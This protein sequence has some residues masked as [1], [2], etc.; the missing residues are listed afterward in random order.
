MTNKTAASLRINSTLL[1]IRWL[2]TRTTTE[3]SFLSRNCALFDILFPLNFLTICHSF[4]I[5]MIVINCIIYNTEIISVVW[6]F[7][8]FLRLQNINNLI[9]RFKYSIVFYWLI[10]P[11]IAIDP[12]FCFET[13]E[14]TYYLLVAAASFFCGRP[15]CFVLP[16]SWSRFSGDQG[17]ASDFR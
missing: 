8:D 10:S 17:A 9:T 7:N 6:T 13:T 1:L 4:H 12:L 3:P 15:G 11:C 5:L 14:E 16:S 2:L